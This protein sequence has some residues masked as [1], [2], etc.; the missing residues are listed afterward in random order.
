MR[1]ALHRL[2]ADQ[3]Q[4]D[5]DVVG[6]EAPQRVLVR[7][8]LAEVQAV[9]VH[10]VE[11]AELVPVE[12]L[13]QAVDRRVVLEQVPDHQRRAR[14]LRPRPRRA[15]RRRRSS[16]GASPRSSACRPARPAIASSA[17]VGTGVASTTASS[18]GSS[19]SSCEIRR[20]ARASGKRCASLARAPL[21]GVAQPRQLA[22]GDRREVAREVRA[23]VA[24][25]ADAHPHR[26][27]CSA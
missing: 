2:L 6:A 1:E 3:C 18:S 14:P 23:P 5:R 9:A 13:A 21:G 17:C 10:V 27:L 15:R 11:L 22:A 7:A 12:Q 8:Q 25:P 19:S 16:P 20:V 4:H 24:E 26:S